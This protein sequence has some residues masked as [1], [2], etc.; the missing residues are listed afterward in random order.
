MEN[1][2]IYYFERR[3]FKNFFDNLTRL[4]NS[5]CIDGPTVNTNFSKKRT[6]LN[7]FQK[8]IDIVN[9]S[10]YMQR[11]KPRIIIDVGSQGASIQNISVDNEIQNPKL[12]EKRARQL[13]GGSFD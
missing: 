10:G 11:Y 8:I 6:S 3:V 7:R 2:Q 12:E 13:V 1:G 4:N 5:R 9:W